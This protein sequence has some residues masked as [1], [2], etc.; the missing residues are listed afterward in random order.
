M[1]RQCSSHRSI[2]LVLTSPSNQVHGIGVDLSK[3]KIIGIL[4][5]VIDSGTSIKLMTAS[6]V[7][8]DHERVLEI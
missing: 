8:I 1:T 5:Q 2:Y 6:I 3:V 7:I 4:Q